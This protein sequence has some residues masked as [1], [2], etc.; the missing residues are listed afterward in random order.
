MIPSGRLFPSEIVSKRVCCVCVLAT[1]PFA[2]FVFAFL[3]PLPPWRCI[4][5]EFELTLFLLALL[6]RRCCTK[7]KES[8]SVQVLRFTITSHSCVTRFKFQ[9]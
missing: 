5:I 8:S 7:G 9:F 6:R 2:P 3:S 4:S 1:A